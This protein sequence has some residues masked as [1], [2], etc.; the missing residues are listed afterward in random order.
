MI[1]LSADKPRVLAETF[2]VLCPGGRLGIRQVG[3]GNFLRAITPTTIVTI[4][5]LQ[6]I[7]VIFTLAASAGPRPVRELKGFKKVL[8]QPGESHEVSFDLS[9]PELGCYDGSGHW[10]VEPGK[11]QVWIAKD[12]AS[13]DPAGFEVK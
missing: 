7:S 5:Q 1:N 3:Q 11:Y 6:P 4:T 10:L 12:S 2:R 8:L 9:G 13:G